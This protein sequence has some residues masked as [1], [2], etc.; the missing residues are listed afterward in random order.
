MP[1]FCCEEKAKMAE[2]FEFEIEGLE[3]L[4]RDLRKAIKTAP[5]QAEETLLEVAKDF[6]KSAKRRANSELK[7]HAREGDQKKKSIKRK[8]GHKKVEDN[9]GATVMVWNS[10]RHFHLI[11]NGHNLVRG[12]R[13]V[14]FVAG[15][16]IM[17]KTKNEYENIIPERFEQ[18]IDEILKECDLN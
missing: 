18:M 12:G 7:P 13:I 1:P 11:E 17:E 3:E 6:K 16:H 9:I 15:K 2:G 10:A 8:W 14:G 4:E 5:A